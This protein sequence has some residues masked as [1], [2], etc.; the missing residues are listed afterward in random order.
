MIARLSACIKSEHAKRGVWWSGVDRRDWHNAAGKQRESETKEQQSRQQIKLAWQ[1]HRRVRCG[2]VELCQCCNSLFNCT[3]CTSAR[4]YDRMPAMARCTAPALASPLLRL[5]PPALSRQY[6][7]DLHAINSIFV[8]VHIRIECIICVIYN[9]CA[10]M[11][12]P[13]ALLPEP[14][15]NLSCLF[16]ECARF[17][18]WSIHPQMHLHIY[19]SLN[20]SCSWLW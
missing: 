6:L 18:R 3:P 15:C 14:A 19:E 9:L 13:S 11:A 12:A 4:I 7:A 17:T 5:P 20:Y 1:V 16:V 8:C 2:A 10:T